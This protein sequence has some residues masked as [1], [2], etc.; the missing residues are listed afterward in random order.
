MRVLEGDLADLDHGVAVTESWE[1][2]SGVHLGDRL[3]G[4]RV[5]AVVRD[6]P[7]LYGEIIIGP[8]LV[9]EGLRDTPPESFFVD[10]G[11]ADL[12][13][14]LAGTD[15]RVLT[16]DAWIDET[17]K[18]TRAGNNIGLWVLLGPAGLYSAIAIVN[19]VLIGA[20]QRRAQLRTISLLGATSRQLRRMALWEAGLIGAAAL[21]V[22][23]AITGLFGWTVRVAT[24]ADVPNQP[25]TMPWL[26][27]AAIAATCA[28]LIMV[29]AL[30]G[31]RHA[32]RPARW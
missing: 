27:L 25:F 2:D 10:P 12:E 7:D 5:V 29:A 30:V 13:E 1:M 18:Q 32:V 22:G 14:L 19:A 4:A 21:L 24:S 6:A 9:P 23:G 8:E 28:A 31:S 15:A 16:A 20:S 11:A 26:P 3:L 17:D